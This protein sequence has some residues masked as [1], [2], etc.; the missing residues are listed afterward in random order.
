[1]FVA[2]IEK[3]HKLT[4]TEEQ[5]M[6]LKELVMEKQG[7]FVDDVNIWK[8]GIMNKLMMLHD[9]FEEDLCDIVEEFEDDVDTQ[10]CPVF[11]MTTPE[12]ST[13]NWFNQLD[14]EN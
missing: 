10:Q 6:A 3:L 12:C 9:D 2:S 13:L 5:R 1:M 8:T 7:E 4:L 11:P 14:M